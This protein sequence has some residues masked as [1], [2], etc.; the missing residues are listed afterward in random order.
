MKSLFLLFILNSFFS[1]YKVPE[2]QFDKF[3]T[4]KFTYEGKE[5]EVIITRT[6]HE[7]TE[8]YNNGKSKIICKIEWVN[9]N[10]YILTGKRLIN[11]KGCMKIG[12][13]VKATIIEATGNKYICDC[14]TANCGSGKIVMIKLE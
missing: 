4:G 3:R 13:E 5:N 14:T 2:G 12:D 10:T 6:K 7:Q 8:V 9:E 1:L 11:A